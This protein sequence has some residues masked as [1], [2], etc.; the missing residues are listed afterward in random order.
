MIDPER[1]LLERNPYF[2]G[3]AHGP[4]GV[5]PTPRI[6]ERTKGD[7]KGFLISTVHRSNPRLGFGWVGGLLYVNEAG[8]VAVLPLNHTSS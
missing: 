3:L 5:R 6:G 4:L 2:Y 1:M 8:D 7:F